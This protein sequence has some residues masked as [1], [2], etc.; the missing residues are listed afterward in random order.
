[1]DVRYC[2]IFLV[3]LSK[4]YSPFFA[5]RTH[6]T[7]SPILSFCQSLNSWKGGGSNTTRTRA[8][9]TLVHDQLLI[10][11]RY[12]PN[13]L[14]WAQLRLEDEALDMREI[15]IYCYIGI[16]IKLQKYLEDSMAKKQ[17]YPTPLDASQYSLLD[18]VYNYDSKRQ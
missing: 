13:C 14:T 17:T 7:L 8:L 16:G 2:S 18:V 15:N 6:P 12:G 11:L 4:E 3:F 1:M 10:L 5:N 9:Q